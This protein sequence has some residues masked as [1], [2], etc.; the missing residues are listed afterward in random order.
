[1]LKPAQVKNEKASKRPGGTITYTLELFR[2]GLKP[3][4]I[5]RK[6]ELSVLTIYG[7]LAQLIAQMQITS[8]AVIW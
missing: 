8:A 1:M 5:A 2:E 4:E 7:H 3:E 6:R